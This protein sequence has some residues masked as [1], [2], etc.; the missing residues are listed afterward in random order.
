MI[1]TYEAFLLLVERY[2][3]TSDE[4]V[5]FIKKHG[6]YMTRD[7]KAYFKTHKSIFI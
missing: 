5:E 4:V 1:N 2:G 6:E 3:Y 7:A